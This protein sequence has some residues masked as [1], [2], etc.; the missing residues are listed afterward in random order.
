MP[1]V[2]LRSDR[3]KIRIRVSK[4]AGKAMAKFS[5]NLSFI[6]Q[7]CPLQ[8]AIVVSEM[9]DRLSPNM[10]PPMTDAIHSGS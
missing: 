5:R 8:A 4:A 9:N 10:A 7:P 2:L 1:S 6:S 3:T